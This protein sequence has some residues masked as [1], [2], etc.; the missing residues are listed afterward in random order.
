MSGD[1]LLS[2]VTLAMVIIYYDVR[3]VQYI[4]LVFKILC[5]FFN[6]MFQFC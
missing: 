1:F 4:S 2:P 3:F 5:R 6:Y